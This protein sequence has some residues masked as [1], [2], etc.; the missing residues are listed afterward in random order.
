[1]RSPTPIP[2]L[3]TPPWCP[4]PGTEPPGTTPTPD[5]IRLLSSSP[6]LPASDT[7]VV[8]LTAVVK[9]K[10][11][12]LMEGVEVSFSSDNDGDLMLKR[13]ITNASGTAEAELTTKTN[14]SNRSITVTASAGGVSTTNTI[15]V[16]GTTLSVSGNNTLEF[17]AST[18]LTINLQDADG[19]PIEGEQL[20]IISAKGNRLDNPA[21]S[22]DFNG[23]ATVTVT[24]EANET[25]TITVTGAGATAQFTLNV[26]EDSLFLEAFLEADPTQDVPLNTEVCV[27]A[28]WKRSGT[29]VPEGNKV[30]FATTRG[31]PSTG[32]GETDADGIAE[33]CIMSDNAGSAVVTAWT[34]DNSVRAEIELLFYADTASE[35]TLQANPAVIGPNASSEIVAVVRDANGNLVKGKNVH[36]SVNGIGSIAPP[37]VTTDQYGR[38]RAIYTA[39]SVASAKDG[40]VITAQVVD[41]PAVTATT[42]LTVARKELFI[43]LGTGSEIKKP[44]STRYAKPYSVMVIDASGNPVAN[45]EVQL[46]IWPPSYRKGKYEWNDEDSIWKPSIS[47]TCHNEDINKNGDLDP[48]EDYNNNGKLEPGGVATTSPSSI[49]T[50]ADGF[51]TFDVEYLRDRAIW[52]QVELTAHAVVEGSESTATTVFWLPAS[53]DDFKN[54]EVPPSGREESP[55]GVAAT[56]ADPY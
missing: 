30:H 14:K 9:D 50:G 2:T 39:G 24:A 23:R 21:P 22:T 25:D 34:D 48:G 16:I 29:P 53:L 41:T 47:E 43:T 38:A 11:N 19:V 7:G 42:T 52:S 56:C 51:A 37:M 36:F 44:D 35:I 6:Q 12:V 28:Q 54:K 27:T 26:S 40:V 45:A 49:T 46:T 1:M 3:L 31:T 8:T 33:F 55:F 20:S 13:T 15:D 18:E 10:S 4:P 17:G 32:T 5:S